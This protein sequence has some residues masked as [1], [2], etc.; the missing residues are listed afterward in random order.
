[1]PLAD[2]LH[3]RPK[4]GTRLHG[5]TVRREQP[6][7]LPAFGQLKVCV[8]ISVRAQAVQIRLVVGPN[9]QKPMRRN[10]RVGWNAPLRRV[11]QIVR[12]AIAGQV[13]PI[14]IRIKELEPILER[15]V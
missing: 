3:L 8:Q 1:M 11:G 4:R 7:R 9:Q 14:R 13:E 2:V 5:H 6:E 12:Q 15:S 10:N